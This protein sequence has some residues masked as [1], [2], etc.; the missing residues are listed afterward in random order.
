[1]KKTSASNKLTL[2]RESLKRLGGADLAKVA[3]GTQLV[4]L[5]DPATRRPP[6][7]TDFSC[8]C[9]IKG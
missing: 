5:D 7:Y 6:P 2:S 9:P 3:G 4:T 1:M 8:L